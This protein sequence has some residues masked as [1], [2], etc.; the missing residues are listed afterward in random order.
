[1]D[2]QFLVTVPLMVIGLVLAYLAW[3]HPRAASPGPLIKD[4]GKDEE[5][6]DEGLA[7]VLGLLWTARNRRKAMR[8]SAGSN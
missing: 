8:E 3:R 5:E 2:L 4:Q 1:M 6:K 7:L